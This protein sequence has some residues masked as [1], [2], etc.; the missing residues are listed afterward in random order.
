MNE[1]PQAPAQL[2]TEQV[3]RLFVRH[4]GAI[5]A[6]VRSLQ[7]SLSDSDDILQET[8]LTLTRKATSFEPGSNFVAWACS[9]ARFKILEDF[10]KKRRVGVLSE[11]ALEALAADAPE[12]EISELRETALNGCLQNLGS[13][14]S[15]LLWRK[16]VGR[17]TSEEMAG[18]LG[19][20]PLAVRV[21]LSKARAVLRDCV[22]LQLKRAQ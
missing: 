11:A 20:T 2:Q 6:F 7:P 3:Q 15:D 4:Q 19:M 10:R 18:G 8:F 21:A 12:E 16:Y 17:Q 13:R 9:I 14:A 5:R 1:D 22:A